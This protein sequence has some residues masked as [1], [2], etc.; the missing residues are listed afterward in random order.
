MNI[1]FAAGYGSSKDVH[2]YE[3]LGL[4]RERI[5]TVGKVGRKLQSSVHSITDGYISHLRELKTNN[6]YSLKFQANPRAV[7]PKGSFSDK[8][9]STPKNIN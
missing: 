2:M 5:Y 9:T 7:L 1:I 4:S 3:A 8:R 6:G